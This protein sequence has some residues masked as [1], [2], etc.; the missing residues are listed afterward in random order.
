MFVRM[1]ATSLTWKRLYF[2]T[3]DGMHVNST[4]TVYSRQ[5]QRR[6]SDA[7]TFGSFE[8]YLVFASSSQRANFLSWNQTGVVDFDMTSSNARLHINPYIILFGFTLIS[9]KKFH[10]SNKISYYVQY[11]LCKTWIFF[12]ISAHNNTISLPSYTVISEDAL[13]ALTLS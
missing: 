7:R 2:V 3:D 13:L 6:T 12:R 5:F 8:I 4:Q 10:I 11:G 1:L 9:I